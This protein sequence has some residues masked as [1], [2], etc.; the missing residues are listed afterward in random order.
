MSYSGLGKPTQ[1]RFLVQR[2]AAS[3]GLG[4]QTK[5]SLCDDK[6]PHMH[7]SI[8]NQAHDS[9]GNNQNRR[10][11]GWR[12]IVFTDSKAAR[13]PQPA[14][15]TASEYICTRCQREV[16]ENAPCHY[17]A[18]RESGRIAGLEEAAHECDRH[19]KFCHDEAH[20][21]GNFQHLITREA[22]AIYNAER[23]RALKA[24]PAAPVEKAK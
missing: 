19:A 12:K 21:G 23:I 8:Y 3:E 22:E 16:P 11:I 20:K 6:A 13:N 5:C 15:S 17:C 18:E 1:N 24:Q 7:E 9:A 14:E 4:A 10:I 2:P